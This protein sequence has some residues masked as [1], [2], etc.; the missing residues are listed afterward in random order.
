M[1]RD[2]GILHAL[3]GIHNEAELDVYP[4]LGASWEGFAI[5][6]TIRQMHAESEACYFWGTPSGPALDLFMIRNGKRLGFECKYGDRPSTTRS[7][8]IACNDLKLD[9]LYVIFPGTQSFPLDLDAPTHPYRRTS[10]ARPS[11]SPH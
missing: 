9:H 1:F 7:M 2:S 4:K 8:K 6:E 10:E 5:E 3:L 11:H